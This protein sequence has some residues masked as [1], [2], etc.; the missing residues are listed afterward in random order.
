M[1]TIIPSSIPTSATAGEKR[2]HRLL[3]RLPDDCVVYYEPDLEGRHPDFVILCPTL[4]VL[5]IEDK[6]WRPSTIRG[7]NRQQITI[8]TKEG[9][10]KSITHP[11]KQARSYNNKLREIAEKSRFGRTF[12][13]DHGPHKGRLTF[14][15]GHLVTLSNITSDQLDES[16]RGFRSVFPES[17]TI[18]RDELLEWENKSPL[19][20]LNRL[21]EFFDPWWPIE[22]LSGQQVNAIR[23]L[24]HPEIELFDQFSTDTL[25]AEPRPVHDQLDLLKTLDLRQEDVAQ[26]VGEGH[27]ILFGVAGSGKTIILLMRARLLAKQ[28]PETQILLICYNSE[29]AKWLRSQLLDYP[30]VTVSTFHAWGIQAGVDFVFNRSDEDHGEALMEQLENGSPE[31]GRYDAILVDEAQDF[32]PV[33]FRCLIKAMKDPEDGDLL[34][35]ADGAQSLYRRNP[36]SWK[37]L[38]IKAQGRTASKKFDLDRNYRNSTE[39]LSL[40]ET[41]ASRSDFGDAN[42]EEIH[43]MRVSPERSGRSTG[44]SPWV[45]LSENHATEVEA[46]VKI[47]ERLLAGRWQGRSIPPLLP[48]EIAI[49]YPRSF[50]DD[51]AL[52]STLPKRLQEKAGVAGRWISKKGKSPENTN[53]VRIQTIHSSKGL[54]FRAVIVLWAGSRPFAKSNEA[55]IEAEAENRRLLYVAMTRAESYLALTGSGK[56][57]ALNAIIKSPACT[58]FPK[59]KRTSAVE[60]AG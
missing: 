1:A 13:H 32:E 39:I 46:A 27:R 30:Q 11:V 15:V 51:K 53:A 44:A 14:P 26:A 54:Q 49:L 43:S 6:N 37:S 18:T 50:Q 22:R 2:L 3:E 55:L 24:I 12:L 58:I 52:L 21:K 20:I 23:A 9:Q 19:E 42:E 10:D 31:S 29:L 45:L 57:P 25:V 60:L 5:V 33:W 34:I 4:G 38:G 47:V 8:R 36:I 56:S 17:E 28:N 40:A 16:G 41:F 35:V 59:Q 7:G 48:Q